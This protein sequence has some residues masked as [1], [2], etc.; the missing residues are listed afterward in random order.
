MRYKVRL[1]LAVLALLVHVSTCRNIRKL[2]GNNLH[3]NPHTHGATEMSG[4]PSLD[5]SAIRDQVHGVKMGVPLTACDDGVHGIEMDWNPNS[6]EEITCFASDII[7]DG[8]P[9]LN[10]TDFSDEIPMHICLDSPI[11][12]TTDLPLSGS[13]RPLWP[14]FGE[15]KYLPPQRWVH[16]L[17]H[18][19]V[20]LL[21]H[22]CM[23]EEPELAA[24]K[25]LVRDCL[26]K[27]VITPYRNIPL[28]MPYAVLTYKHG[29]LISAFEPK[30]E[31]D[32]NLVIEFI[33]KYALEAPET[34]V[35]KDGQ[36]SAGLV[37]SATKF[38]DLKETK[39]NLCAFLK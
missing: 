18:G 16:S 14:K 29:L 36:Y 10:I 30:F 32:V 34:H 4:D 39:E 21:Y 27:H 25:S 28:H 11:K 31:G 1:K 37:Q 9:S 22:P 3:R 2:F 8:I 7:N 15:Y 13:H 26:G 6:V 5:I 33:K 20:A 12:Y 23:R 24:L 17:E 19:A 38:S 35:L